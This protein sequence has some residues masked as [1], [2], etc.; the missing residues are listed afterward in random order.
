MHFIDTSIKHR[1]TIC[2]FFVKIYLIVY[3]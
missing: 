2:W 3:S 1:L